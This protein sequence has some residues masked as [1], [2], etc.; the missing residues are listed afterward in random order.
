MIVMKT[1]HLYIAFLFL[2]AS[3]SVNAQ[4]VYVFDEFKD[5]KIVH[6]KGDVVYAKFNY[7][8]TGERMMFLSDDNTILELANPGEASFVTI[9]GRIFEHIKGSIFYERINYDDMTYYIQWKCKVMS[10]GKASGYGTTSLTS[11]ISSIN[12]I[13]DGG[14]SVKLDIAEDFTSLQDNLYYLKIKNSQ[15]RF[16]SADT[17][18]KLFKGNED[19]IKQYVKDNN[20]V[21]NNTDDVK[22]AVEY[23]QQFIKK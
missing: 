11:S 2:I 7:D 19:A 4:T 5:G 9:D 15:K 6:K 12:S 23:C 14:R 16:Y 20:L 8:T 21:F 10:K 3:I 13:N 1:R 22:K 18:A 17:L